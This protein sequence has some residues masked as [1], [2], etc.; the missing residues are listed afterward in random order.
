MRSCASQGILR[1]FNRTI[2]KSSYRIIAVFEIGIKKMLIITQ[3]KTTIK[4]HS[5]LL[6]LELWRY[7]RIHL[8]SIQISKEFFHFFP[9]H[10]HLT[11]ETINDY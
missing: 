8:K 5:S 9:E 1:C 4:S 10:A 2:A 7:A 3:S 11:I 6:W